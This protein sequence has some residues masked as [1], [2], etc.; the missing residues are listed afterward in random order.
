MVKQLH[1]KAYIAIALALLLASCATSPG[2]S[3]LLPSPGVGQLT[4]TSL[5]QFKHIFVIVMENKESD[6]LI[7]SSKA[8]YL[9]ALAKQYGLAANYY[10]IRHPSLPN[11][12]ALTGGSTFGITSDCTDCTVAQP[13]LVDQLEA[14]GKSWK[15]YM[16]SMPSP[17]YIGDAPP[18]YRQKHN[19]FI[20]YDDVR[21]NPQRCKQIV[22]FT[23]FAADVAADALPNYVWITPNMCDDTHDCPI[24][25][26]DAWLK[27]WVPTII[28]SQAWKDNSVLFITYDEGSGN[29]GCCTDAAGGHI[30]TLVISPLSKPGYRSPIGYDHYSLLR[31]IERAWGLPELGGATCDCAPPMADFFVPGT[32]AGR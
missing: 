21:T 9:N 19:P 15:A 18:L 24:N 29:A 8:P 12:L 31:T 2:T 25:A 13:N 23:Q 14:A 3:A 1:I 10:A 11:Y 22:P 20:Y 30:A 28:S 17:C 4:A 16:E 26:G 7:G 27:T 5:P 32:V 6:Q